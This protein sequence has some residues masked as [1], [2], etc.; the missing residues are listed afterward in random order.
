MVLQIQLFLPIVVLFLRDN[1]SVI[2]LKWLLYR[3]KWFYRFS[4][5]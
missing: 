1:F 5:F 2:P 4:C 3:F